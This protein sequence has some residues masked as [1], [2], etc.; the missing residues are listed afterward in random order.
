MHTGQVDER[1][2][3]FSLGILLTEF[4]T[5]ADIEY[6]RPVRS[7][8]LQAGMPDSVIELLEKASAEDVA[9][10]LPSCKAMH[11]AIIDVLERADSAPRG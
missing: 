1:T 6:I 2:D 10:R 3:V 8:L 7:P 11:N 5:G 4:L 9:E